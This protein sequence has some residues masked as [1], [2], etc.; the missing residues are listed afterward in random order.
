MPSANFSQFNSPDSDAGKNVIAPARQSRLVL[1]L[2]FVYLIF[3][4]AFYF[5]SVKHIFQNYFN[6]PFWDHWGWIANYCENGLATATLSPNNE[7]MYFFPSFLY[8]LDLVYFNGGNF[9]LVLV[10]VLLQSACIP[11]LVLPLL[12]N[13]KVPWEMAA[14]FS[15]FVTVSMF[16]SAQGENL[17]WP[18]QVALVLADFSIIVTLLLYSKFLYLSQN[19]LGGLK[20]CMYF[21]GAVLFAV[22]ATFSFGH[23]MLAWPVLLLLGA[24]ERIPRRYLLILFALMTLIIGFYFTRYFT[25]S[26][27]NGSSQFISQLLRLGHYAVLFVGLPIFGV[28]NTN[29]DISKNIFKYLIT[30]AA[31]MT[32][33]FFILQYLFS[34]KLKNKH[35]ESAYVGILILCLATALLTALNRANQFP[36]TQALT[37]RYL[38]VSLLFWIS[39]TALIGTSV[40]EREP[41]AGMGKALLCVIIA[42]TSFAMIPSH[43]SIAS[44]FAKTKK[45]KGT[46]AFALSSGI[47]DKEN[48]E[49]ELYPNFAFIL[50]CTKCLE[51]NHFAVNQDAELLGKSLNQCYE[52]LK[53][54]CCIGN[55]DQIVPLHGNS[56]DA[57]RLAGWAWDEVQQRPVRKVIFVDCENKI[58]GI[59]FTGFSRTDVA[60]RFNNNDML[61]TGWV[62]Y[63]ISARSAQCPLRTLALLNDGLHVASIEGV[64]PI[65]LPE[66]GH[67]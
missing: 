16:W 14:I 21:T 36:I 65:N 50:Q 9:L 33:C 58:R 10:T 56:A 46:V 34:S 63:I 15:G 13:H 48:I 23:G 6:F 28:N 54:S 3:A 18:Y 27:H 11:M 37:S 4:A 67:K 41:S 62:G 60:Q 26:V 59:G 7:H 40:A 32:A 49:K 47:L 29:I 17:Y 22:V 57:S 39:L 61:Q 51:K 52:M 42:M 53:R 2:V 31:T 5:L 66:E 30:I 25:P 44:W 55:I 38:T 12:R 8:A 64:P 45:E 1:V 19:L 35:G 24:T 20:S 43:L